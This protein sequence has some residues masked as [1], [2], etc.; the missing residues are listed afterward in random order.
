MCSVHL[1]I[2]R[3]VKATSPASREETGSRTLALGR[4]G[5]RQVGTQTEGHLPPSPLSPYVP[6]SPLILSRVREQTDGGFRGTEK[7][8]GLSTP[9]CAWEDAGGR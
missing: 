3:A 9:R 4:A 5:E 2:T 7:V 6:N 8:H 1:Q